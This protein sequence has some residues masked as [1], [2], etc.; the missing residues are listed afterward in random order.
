MD[1]NNNDAKRY[2]SEEISKKSVLDLTT[3]IAVGGIILYQLGWLYWETFFN[4]L[5]IDSSFIDIPIEKIISTTWL[6]IAVVIIVFHRVLDLISTNKQI[7]PLS[8]GLLYISLALALLYFVYNTEDI[9]YTL[10]TLIF[11]FIIFSLGFVKKFL[12]SITGKKYMYAV[13]IIMYAI[14]F[15]F[16][17]S[18][19]TKDASII[20]S[21]KNNDIEIVMNEGNKIIKGKFVYFMNDKYFILSKNKDKKIVTLVINNSEINH[22]KLV[23][24]KSK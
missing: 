19:A 3:L 1:N 21:Y 14:A 15:Y 24:S 20:K 7:I 22:T 13:A 18:K 6:I 16:Y 9:W 10:A 23:T 4:S 8:D 11:L 5:N 2:M 12:G 17:F